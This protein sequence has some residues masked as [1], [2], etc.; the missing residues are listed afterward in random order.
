MSG[1]RTKLA[2]PDSYV[3]ID[4]ETTGLD[5]TFCDLIEVAALKVE[6]GKPT[7]TFETL[8]KPGELPIPRFIE[9]L[10]GIRSAELEGAPQASEVIGSFS[11]FI[12]N[13]PIVGYN[14]CFDVRFI[15]KARTASGLDGT[16]N[17]LVDV[18][19]IARHVF[20]EEICSGLSEVVARC[21]EA[22]G[23]TYDRAGR[24][25]RAMPDV[26]ATR[27]A[28]EILKPM[29]VAMYGEDPDAGFEE[30]QVQKRRERQKDRPST[31]L[32]TKSIVPTVDEI[33]DSSPFYGRSVC[34]TGKLGSMGRR[35]AM[36]KAVNLGATIEG[37]VTKKLDYLIVGNLDFISSIKDGK[38][39]KLK[40]AEQLIERGQSLQILSEDFFLQFAGPGGAQPQPEATQKTPKKKERRPWYSDEYKKVRNEFIEQVEE[41]HG[42]MSNIAVNERIGN[43]D[44]SNPPRF[45]PIDDDVYSCFITGSGVCQ[46]ETGTVAPIQP[47]DSGEAE[48]PGRAIME[49]LESAIAQCCAEHGGRLYRSKAKGAKFA[50]VRSGWCWRYSFVEELH[51]QG[52]KVTSLSALVRHMGLTS[53]WD[54]DHQERYWEESR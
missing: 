50:I 45:D 52:Y 40:K 53:L 12:G 2:V 36:Q 13:L 22:S 17:E 3:V 30:I 4:T 46:A 5:T 37:S 29:L 14:V 32:D 24:F 25:H 26:A 16:A 21:E 35:E 34:F 54:A 10:T 41:W 47:N 23:H 9:A 18:M 31:R 7:D 6:G 39:A 28:F 1:T 27:F 48:D 11:S 8:V 49:R 42:H 15:D 33:D 20:R 44:R 38:S 19:R 43:L 51:G